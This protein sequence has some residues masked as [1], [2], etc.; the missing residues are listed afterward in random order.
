MLAEYTRTS[1]NFATVTRRILEKIPPQDAKM[2]YVYDRFDL[3]L[4]RITFIQSL[5]VTSLSSIDISS[6]TLWKM[7]SHIY[8]WLMK[9]LEGGF[10]L[11]F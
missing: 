2:S 9:S 5:L 8:V 4:F 10:H 7:A 6:I 11:H 1:G 3:I